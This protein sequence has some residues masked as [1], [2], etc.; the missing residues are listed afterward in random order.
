MAPKKAATNRATASKRVQSTPKPRNRSRS[1]AHARPA[2]ATV[3]PKRAPRQ[4]VAGLSPYGAVSV[5]T[6]AA[7]KPSGRRTAPARKPK[8]QAA[9][10]II[11]VEA[12]EKN[13]EAAPVAAELA[14]RRLRRPAQ[15][16]VT[17][18]EGATFVQLFTRDAESL[19]VFWQTSAQ[20]VGSL[21]SEI[22]ERT[23]ALARPTLRVT[24]E[25]GLRP[26]FV[27]LPDEARSCT[28]Q[29]DPRRI[30]YRVEYGYTLPSGE[31]RRLAE[32]ATVRPP[33]PAPPGRVA[34]A[35]ARVD[36]NRRPPTLEESRRRIEQAIRAGD[37]ARAHAIAEVAGV[38]VVA[39]LDRRPTGGSSEASVRGGASDQHR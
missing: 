24:D 4:A 2:R 17:S 27:L 6:A 12:S 39:V 8:A 35:R 11:P 32:S 36:M 25:R 5:S 3:S 10:R 15:P 1:A 37:W 29:V 16:P 9:P 34:T 30:A 38:E 19:L 13:R 21:L 14:S 33:S 23:L 22:G 18:R 7:H 28:L 31:F 26:E 20:A